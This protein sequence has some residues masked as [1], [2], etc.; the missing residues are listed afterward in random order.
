[1]LGLKCLN[2]ILIYAYQIVLK[3]LVIGRH[4]TFYIGLHLCVSLNI[5]L[6]NFKNLTTFKNFYQKIKF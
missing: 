1:M 5:N 3:C 2:E 4:C 6:N